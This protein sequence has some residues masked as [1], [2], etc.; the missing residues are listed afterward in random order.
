M[1]NQYKT[2]SNLQHEEADRG[3]R[4]ASLNI[5]FGDITDND[6]K[7]IDSKK[8]PTYTYHPI[9]LNFI[10]GTHG[11]ITSGEMPIKSPK[12]LT[13]FAKINFNQ[14]ASSSSEPRASHETQ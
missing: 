10:P 9:D 6:Q 3:F 4:K 13:S 7:Q 1:E 8:V 12:S 5:T 11:F 2:P 14:R